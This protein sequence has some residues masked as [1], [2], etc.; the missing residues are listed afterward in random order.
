MSV[1]QFNE[2]SFRNQILEN[3]E[4]T[5]VDFWAPWCSYCR[6]IAPAYDMAAE[7]FGGRLSFGKVNIDELPQLEE[8]Y[9][10]EVIPTILLFR[11]GKPAARIV[12]PDSMA[13][14]KEFIKQQL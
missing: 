10:I 8:Q 1:I 9:D 2:E 14:L 12:A 3:K 13:K 7:E 6:R 4:L 11:D 5:L